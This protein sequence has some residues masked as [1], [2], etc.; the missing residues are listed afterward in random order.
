MPVLA[1]RW[2]AEVPEE[3]VAVF[4][5]GMRI[6]R[7]LR[8]DRWWPV[9]TAMPRMLRHLAEHPGA[10]LL[11]S[12][13]WLGRTTILL[14]YWRRVEDLLAFAGDRDA[15]HAAAWRDFNRRVGGDGTVGVWHETY[16]ARPGS[17]EAVY[18]NMPAFGLAGA[19]SPVRVTPATTSARRRLSGPAPR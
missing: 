10:G 1:G 5:I 12:H 19:T 16:L 3:G 4:L 6:N 17:A 15:P 14:S 8:V 9:L 18:V 2:T 7:P 11:G 13:T